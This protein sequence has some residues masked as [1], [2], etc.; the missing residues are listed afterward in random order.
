M[1][2]MGVDSSSQSS[3]DSPSERGWRFWLIFISIAS[4]L[5]LAALELSSVATALPRI[6]D[7]LHGSQFVWVGSAYALAATA[8]VPLSGALAQAFG[9]RSVMLL[10]LFLFAAGSAVCGAATSLNMLIAG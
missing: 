7:D 5:F 3:M 4:S 1:G 9:R 6:I 2:K 8:F 10:A